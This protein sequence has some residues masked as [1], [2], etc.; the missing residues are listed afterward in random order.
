VGWAPGFTFTGGKDVDFRA[1][2]PTAEA[3]DEE[4]IAKNGSPGGGGR[5]DVPGRDHR[6][7]KRPG[8]SD[9]PKLE[10]QGRSPTSTSARSRPGT[11]RD[12]G[13][14][15]GLAA[16][17]GDTRDPP[18]GL[19]RDDFR[20]YAFLRRGRPRSRARS[21]RQG[22]AVAYRHW[23][24]GKRPGSRRVQQTGRRGRLRRAGYALKHK[25]RR[26]RRVKNKD[27]QFVVPSLASANG[28]RQ[29]GVKGAAEPGH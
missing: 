23:R 25:F 11:T 2:R 1:L 29:Q 12:Q 8:A 6:V 10:R 26:P 28:P 9:R 13:A 24:Q 20:L 18:L 22:R 21:R 4:A 5:S 27:G 19:L 16:E 14:E 7:L 15:P 17:A 3:E